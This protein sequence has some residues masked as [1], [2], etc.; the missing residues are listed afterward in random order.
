MVGMWKIFIRGGN[1]ESLVPRNIK[2]QSLITSLYFYYYSSHV[3]KECINL[4]VSVFS[5][6]FILVLISVFSFVRK[7]SKSIHTTRKVENYQRKARHIFS[8]MRGN[9][10]SPERA[11]FSVDG[12]IIRGSVTRVVTEEVEKTKQALLDFSIANRRT[13]GSLFTPTDRER[14]IYS[15]C[16]TFS[17]QFVVALPYPLGILPDKV[18]L[19]AFAQ[20]MAQ[21]SPAMR[22]FTQPGREYFISRDRKEQP[23]DKYGDAVA[24]VEV[25]GGDHI[26]LHEQLKICWNGMMRKAGFATT[27]VARNIFHGSVE[28][29]YLKKYVDAQTSKDAIIPDIL[30]HNYPADIN[31]N[32]NAVGPAIFDIKTVRIDKRGDI[33]RAGVHGRGNKIFRVVKKKCN[34]CRSSYTTNRAKKLDDLFAPG[35]TMKPFQSTLKN[36]FVTGNAIPHWFVG[37]WAN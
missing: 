36:Q 27:M 4:A 31:G 33:Y 10:T 3:I 34:A 1:F 24:R 28:W 37:R 5:W 12:K 30:V 18:L 23:A 11:G 7:D 9:E 6:D 32:G 19:E 20:Y 25:N 13:D 26:R 8:F 15:N 22:P 14:L 21:P 2:Y 17:A 35:V 29:E 16:D